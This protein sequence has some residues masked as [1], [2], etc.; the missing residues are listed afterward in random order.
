MLTFQLNLSLTLPDL[1]F[2]AR[3]DAAARLGF[4]YVECFWPPDDVLPQL[5]RLLRDAGVEL[6]LCNFYGGDLAAGERGLLNDP[7]RSAEFFA[8]LPEAF[9]LA[10]ATGCR[11]FHALPGRRNPS[12]DAQAEQQQ[13]VDNLQRTCAAAADVGCTV[14]VET[15]NEKDVPG[16]LLPTSAAAEAVIGRV[17][18]ENLRFQ[19]DTYHLQRVEGDI[20]ATFR[21]LLP[22]IGHIQLADVPG[23]GVPGSGELNFPFLLQ[24]IV[25]AGYR[26][27]IG[28]E[29][30]PRGDLAAELAWLP[31]DRRGP[32]PLSTLFRPATGG[33]L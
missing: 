7:L 30:V 22:L 26:G 21:R 20:T 29:F 15:I 23:R 31:A 1:P 11:M 17:N 12:I 4:R 3:I 18:A 27:H 32:L 24:Q 8:R 19:F 10:A 13:L 5:P 28:L 9:E 33:A 14:L 25:A 6:R 2:A 16:Y